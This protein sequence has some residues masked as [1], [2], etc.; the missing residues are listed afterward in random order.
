MRSIRAGERGSIVTRRGVEWRRPGQRQRALVMVPAGP[1]T[2]LRSCPPVVQHD[3]SG[4][5]V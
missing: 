5:A 4:A 3:L 2:M 1:V